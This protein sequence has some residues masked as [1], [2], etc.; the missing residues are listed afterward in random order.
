MTDD[1]SAGRRFMDG[2]ANWPG[3]DQD[4]GPSPRWPGDD[5]RWPT[6]A[7]QGRRRPPQQGP[8]GERPPRQ[9]RPARDPRQ[10]QGRP[11]G[12]PPDGRARPRR[13]PPPGGPPP[14]GGWPPGQPPAGRQPGAPPPGRPPG[15]PP[16]APPQGR[17]PA[18]Q[19]PDDPYATEMFSPLNRGADAEPPEP[20]LLTHR[21]PG[22]PIWHDPPPDEQMTAF[23]TNYEQDPDMPGDPGNAPFDDGLTAKQKRWR[24]VRRIM[25]AGVTAFVLIPIAIFTVLYFV[26]DVPSPYEIASQQNKTVTYNYADGS[27]MA[28]DMQ[29]GNRV[30]LEPGQIPDKIKYAAYAAEDE[31]FQTNA[32]FDI[33]GILRAVKNQLTGGSGG[34]ST[35]T[36]Q[37]IKTAT[38]YDDYSVT[39][40]ATEIV[41]AFKMS[42]QLSKS[43]IITAYLNTIYFGRGA[44]GIQAASQ[45]YFAKDVGQLTSAQ[46]AYLAGIIQA[47]SNG[48]DLSYAKSRWTYVMDQMVANKWLPASERSKATFPKPVSEEKT[49]SP[50]FEGSRRNLKS[51]IGSELASLGYSEEQV[52]TAGYTVHTTINKR[53][54]RIAE[55]VVKDVMKGQPKKLHEAFVA[56][57]PTS[58]GVRAYYGGPYDET[59]YINWASKGRN[60][61]STMKAFDFTALLKQGKGGPYTTYDGTSPRKFG[62]VLVRN[63]EGEQCPDCTVME[64]MK[65]S[66]NTVFFDMVFNDVGPRAVVQAVKDAGISNNSSVSDL[67]GNIAI[68]GGDNKI[69]PQDMASAYGTFAADGVQRGSHLVSKITTPDGDVI[70]QADRSGKP[71][72]APDR[73]KSKQIAGNVTMTLEPVLAHSELRCADG[74]DCAGKTGT[75]E[76]PGHPGE[77]SQAWMVGY[78]RQISAAAY[79]GDGALNPIRDSY[80]SPIYGSG[81]PGSIWEQFM[82]RYHEG[83]PE[84][85]FP[86][87]EVMGEPP[88]PPPEPE[89]TTTVPP[90]EEPEE[91]SRPKP[92]P[93]GRPEETT[94]TTTPPTTTEDDDGGSI[95]PG[96]GNGRPTEEEQTTEEEQEEG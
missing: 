50:G 42:N 63:S 91:T 17:P 64:A 93:P 67:D 34:G 81:L 92:T 78:S 82:N 61:G 96:N 75:H 95:F 57:D 84:L 2:D 12:P 30:V 72:F 59:D 85:P 65:R 21:M 43:E 32:G 25:Y 76:A 54:Q 40:K 28:K 80:G 11:A 6:G 3:S 26:L 62:D 37:Y 70:Y 52:R 1:G 15:P 56:V 89:T 45:A 39:R 47:P 71:A 60:P 14:A 10:Q 49:E 22:D 41:K 94:T 51:A 44:Y 35:I 79:V 8:G 73:Q 86:E 16:G 5:P 23:V 38:N 88:P 18:G 66:V 27:V 7:E 90:S 74:R 24:L 77:N 87:V 68:G 4:R 13:T 33:M 36:Q 58:G 53:A 9:N 20:E 69:T 29:D 48:D 19:P 31:T 83:L 46:A 55:Q